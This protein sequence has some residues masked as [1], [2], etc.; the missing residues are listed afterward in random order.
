[1]ICS[2]PPMISMESSL[3][4]D[5]GH[6][7]VALA[8]A[9]QVASSYVYWAIIVTMVIL[10]L[11][12]LIT[13][14][15]KLSPFGRLSYYAR[16]PTDQLLYNMRSSRFYYPLKRAL[17]FDPSILMLL[18]ALAILLY[19][20]SGIIGYL[21]AVLMGLANSLLAFGSGAFLSGVRYLVGTLLLAVISYLLV[22]MTIIFVNWIFG[23]LGRVAYR[24]MERIGPLLRIFEFGGIFTG[25]SFL[26]LWIALNFAAAA[27]RA[28]FL[29][30]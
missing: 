22:L 13:D 10:L 14:A 7:V 17:G 16:R 9:I 12:R 25:W 3:L 26:I 1:M 4:V 28:I 30:F 11:M 15:L 6:M 5:A 29:H 8:S 18:I 24:A 23:L 21:F 27:V 20:V 19:V 2:P